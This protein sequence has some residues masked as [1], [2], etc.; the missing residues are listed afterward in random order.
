[1]VVGG[2]VVIVVGGGGTGLVGG[3]IE[4]GTH[5][6]RGGQVSPGIVGEY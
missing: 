5:A 2:Q 1:M 6:P 3:G 4:S